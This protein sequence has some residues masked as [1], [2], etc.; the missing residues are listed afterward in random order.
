MNGITI[1]TGGGNA[2]STGT[3]SWDPWGPMQLMQTRV[4]E[5]RIELIYE[6]CPSFTYTSHNMIGS[7]PPNKITRRVY[8]TELIKEDQGQWIGPRDGYYEFNDDIHND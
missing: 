6:Q 1:N 2:T 4:Y 8:K 7:N 5:D 3:A